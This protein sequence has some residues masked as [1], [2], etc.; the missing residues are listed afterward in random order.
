[1]LVEE[2][3]FLAAAIEDERIAP[4][5]PRHDLAFARF[6]DKQV[7]D[8]LLIERLR[9]RE[10]HVDFLRVLPRVAEQPRM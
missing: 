4:F 5:Q 2:Q 9:C 6:L 3:R 1:M 10:A 7:V 8:G